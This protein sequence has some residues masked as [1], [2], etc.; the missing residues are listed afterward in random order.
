M[1][2]G[3]YEI[4]VKS[5]FFYIC[6]VTEGWKN[7]LHFAVT[8]NEGAVAMIDAE[9]GIRFTMYNASRVMITPL[10]LKW[11]GLTRQYTSCRN[12]QFGVEQ[13]G[14]K[15]PLPKPQRLF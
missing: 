2:N 8:P 5:P 10:P 4:P 13:F 9:Y 3:V 1:T 14:Y 15:A 12:F 11:N 7:N 6:G